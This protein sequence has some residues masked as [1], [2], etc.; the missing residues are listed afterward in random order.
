M[1]LLE[2]FEQ[3]GCR[4]EFLDQ[5]LGQ[6]PQAHLRLQIRGAVAEYE[7]TLIA[8]RMRRGL[9]M[10]LRAGILLPWTISPYGYRVHPDHPCDPAGVQIE[11]TEGAMVQELFARSLEA[12]GTLLGLAKHLLQLGI[13]SPRGNRRWS[14]ASLHGLLSNPAYTGE[15]YAG[16]T[17]AQPARIRRSAIHPMGKPA[18]S[19]DPTLPEVWTLAAIIPPLVGQADFDRVQAKLAP[20]KRQAPRKNQAHRDL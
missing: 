12:D 8:E 1:V 18:H 14:A 20:K 19:Q 17:H 5:P 10:K 7:R 11:P 6:D 3:A 2:A 4:I 13:T 15:V 16:R 9:Q